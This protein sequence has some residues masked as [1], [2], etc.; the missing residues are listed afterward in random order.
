M[1]RKKNAQEPAPPPAPTPTP[2]PPTTNFVELSDADD[3]FTG[4]AGT[5][6]IYGEGGNDTL[7]GAGGND[8]LFGRDGADV[9]AGGAGNDYLGGGIGFDVLAGGAGADVFAFYGNVARDGREVDVI[10]DFDAAAG[11]RLYVSDV[12]NRIFQSGENPYDAG[13]VR[14]VE[15]AGG[16]QFQVDADGGGD[17][18]HTLAFLEGVSLTTLGGDYLL[19]G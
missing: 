6:V 11:D 14:A 13:Y 12:F 4:T 19:I 3:R 9:L 1:A 5:D 2:P 17:A 7:D 15:V 8:T 16:V 18:F 10:R